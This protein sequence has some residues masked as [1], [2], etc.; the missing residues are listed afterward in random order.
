MKSA[1][2]IRAGAALALSLAV[3]SAGAGTAVAAPS[4]GERARHVRTTAWDLPGGAAHAVYG[5]WTAA[6]EAWR[7]ATELPPTSAPVRVCKLV[8][9]WD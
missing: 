1:R 5:H 8:N 3:L 7:T 2:W 6:Q 4:A 9:G